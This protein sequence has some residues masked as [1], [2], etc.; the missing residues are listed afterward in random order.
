[1]SDTCAVDDA[2]HF[3][4]AEWNF[5]IKQNRSVT[6]PFP[7]SLMADLNQV[8]QIKSNPQLAHSFS[9]TSLPP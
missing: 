4:P 2:L 5:L 3:V 7:D 8:Y 9:S 6:S 1:M